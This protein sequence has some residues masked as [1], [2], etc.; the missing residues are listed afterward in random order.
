MKIGTSTRGKLSDKIHAEMRRIAI[1]RHPY[2]VC[3]G[4]SGEGV[5]LQGGHLIPKKSSTATRFDLMNLFTQCRSC[6]Y[7]HQ[8]NPHIFIGWFINEYGMDEYLDLVE[9]SKKI[10]QY[11]IIDLKELLEE[12]KKI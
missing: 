4:A 5:V 10:K 2:C 6:N 7:I 3:C 11:K 1:K 9:R 8:F 12:Y